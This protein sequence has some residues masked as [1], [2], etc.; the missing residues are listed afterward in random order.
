[1]TLIKKIFAA[2]YLSSVVASSCVAAE[3]AAR[4]EV[5]DASKPYKIAR[6]EL[7]ARDCV[8]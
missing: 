6:F 2:T 3:I 1:M 8:L 4:A 5:V 7:N